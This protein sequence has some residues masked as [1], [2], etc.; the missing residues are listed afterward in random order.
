MTDRYAVLGDEPGEDAVTLVAQADYHLLEVDRIVAALAEH[1]RRARIV[2]PV[3]AWKPLHSMRP[4]VRRLRQLVAGSGRR[5]G[6]PI[7]LETLLARSTA[8]LVLNDWGVPRLLVETARAAGH[9]TVALVEG[10]QDY[11]DVDTGLDRQAYRRVDHVF[12]LGP[13]A[14]ALLGESRCTSV[15]SERLMALFSAPVGDAGRTAVINSNFTYGVLREARRAWLDGA[16]AAADAAAR[17]WVV[18]RHTAER[19]RSRH[20]VAAASVD[21]LLVTAGFV[22]SRFST[23]AL[24]ALA[25]GVELRYHNPHDEREPTFQTQVEG[26]EVTRSVAELEQALR[27]EPRSRAEVREAAA[28]FLR[29]HVLLDSSS[30]PSQRVAAG[31]IDLLR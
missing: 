3:V 19:G 23:V 21:E 20:A 10:V 9:P 31:I 15:G 6:E 25:R 2:V 7:D 12:T 5:L 11:G 24:D 22:V 1:G 18:S 8:V 27:V 29:R 14:A 17:P 13:A 4:T 28:P 26:F 30:S 16:V